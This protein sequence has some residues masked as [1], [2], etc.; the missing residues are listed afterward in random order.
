MKKNIQIYIS[1]DD[2]ELSDIEAIQDR[3]E[4]VFD[5]YEDKRIQMTIQDE[6][7]VRPGRR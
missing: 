4:D 5:E 3:L 7:L 6:P 2:V 1:V